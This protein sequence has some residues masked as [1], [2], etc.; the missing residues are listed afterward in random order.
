MGRLLDGPA[1]AGRGN[2]ETGLQADLRQVTTM[3]TWTDPVTSLPTP[4]NLFLAL[5]VGI[6]HSQASGQP[7]SLL[8][9]QI[10]GCSE[11]Q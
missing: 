10:D 6:G 2:E 4:I 5:E 1:A 11:T 3:M 9:V 7:L 8:W